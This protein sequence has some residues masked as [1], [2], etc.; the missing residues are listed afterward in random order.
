MIPLTDEKQKVCDICK[1]GFSTDDDDNKKD[2]KVRDHCHYTGK[3]RR[4]AYNTCNLRQKTPIK[5]IPVVFHNG[6]TFDYHFITY[7]LAKKFEGKLEC[8]GE[9]TEKYIT[10]LV[11][12]SKEL[13]NGKTITYRLKFIDSF[14]FMSI[15]LSSLVDNLSEIYKKECKGC[16]GKKSNQCAILLGLKIIN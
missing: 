5:K 16:E 12:I 3:F 10:F 15:S 13:D 14:I 8:L 11:P 6:T 7:Q 4:A 1:K 2:H 9:N